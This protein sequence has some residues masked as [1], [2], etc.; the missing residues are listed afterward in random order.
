MSSGIWIALVVVISLMIAALMR[1]RAVAKLKPVIEAAAKKHKA[2]IH[3]SFLGMPQITKVWKGHA[4]RLTPMNIS[5]TSPEGGGEMTSVDFDWP[6]R[7]VGEFRV[8]ERIEARQNAVPVILTGGNQPFT[9]GGPQLDRRYS[10]AGTNPVAALQVLGNARVAES[11]I[12]LPGGADVH[13]RGGRCY[14]T[15]KGYP[16][17]VEDVDCLFATCELLLEASLDVRRGK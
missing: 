2:T 5:T 4:M 7:D 16:S 3:Q 6:W 14:V 13:V 9:L 17:A 8:R 15:V 10:A 12:S 11:L 1:G